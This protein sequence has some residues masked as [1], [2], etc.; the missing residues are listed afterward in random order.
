MRISE[1]PYIRHEHDE[2]PRRLME[3]N[4]K[5]RS[6]ANCQACHRQADKGYFGEHG[7]NI[8]GYGRWDD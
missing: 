2:I 6:R 4:P 1:L 7:V 5:V 3:G 8:P